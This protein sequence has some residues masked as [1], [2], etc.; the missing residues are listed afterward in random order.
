MRIVGQ[1]LRYVFHE[2]EKAM[3]DGIKLAYGIC[4]ALPRLDEVM[5]SGKEAAE[6]EAKFGTEDAVDRLMRTLQPDMAPRVS[7]R[8]MTE[9]GDERK[10][11][12]ST[13]KKRRSKKGE[14]KVRSK[15][16]KVGSGNLYDVLAQGGSE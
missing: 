14:T 8:E 12:G 7:T 11:S 1:I 13:Q 5:V 6:D 3:P 4:K 16:Q 15:T 2:N 9:E 10:V